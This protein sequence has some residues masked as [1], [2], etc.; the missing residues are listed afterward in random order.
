MF[1]LTEGKAVVRFVEGTTHSI[2]VH[3][4]PI[5]NDKRPLF[6]HV[7]T[8]NRFVSTFLLLSFR[9]LQTHTPHLN[10]TYMANYQGPSVCPPQGREYSIEIVS[11]IQLGT[12]SAN[13]YSVLQRRLQ[14]FRVP[15]FRT[16]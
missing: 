16:H 1:A 7:H 12:H 11:N 4:Q 9:E 14:F 13:Q 6:F 2:H 15:G 8:P 10:L 3:T 5:V